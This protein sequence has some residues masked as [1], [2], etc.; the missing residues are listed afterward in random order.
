M[1]LKKGKTPSSALH[2][3][4]SLLLAKEQARANISIKIMVIV[5]D[6]LKPG[7][8]AEVRAEQVEQEVAAAQNTRTQRLG[9]THGR[10]ATHMEGERNYWRK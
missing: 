2:C 10:W 3:F 5:K 4:F 7:A 6:L 8:V 1:I 9:N